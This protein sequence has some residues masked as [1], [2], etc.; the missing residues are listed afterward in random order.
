MGS[1]DSLGNIYVIAYGG[2]NKNIIAKFDSSFNL[3]WIIEIATNIINNP[4]LS[5]DESFLY[6]FYND[7]TKNVI[8]KHDA[9]TGAI[10][11]SYDL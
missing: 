7:G 6:H 3:L 9:T 1:A 10:I 5:K 8:S 4:I 2:T 11:S